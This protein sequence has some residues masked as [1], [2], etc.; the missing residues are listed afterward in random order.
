MSDLGV[1]LEALAPPIMKRAQLDALRSFKVPAIDGT[2]QSVLA[3][4]NALGFTFLNRGLL[5]LCFVRPRWIAGSLPEQDFLSSLDRMYVSETLPRD[6][7]LSWGKGWRCRLTL[8]ETLMNGRCNDMNLQGLS[9][10]VGALDDCALK[11]CHRRL[12]YRCFPQLTLMR[13]SWEDRATQ[14]SL[15]PYLCQKRNQADVNR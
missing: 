2:D 11:I 7:C 14:V 9:T 13:S 12:T 6:C 15:S 4:E 5:Y 1:P 10:T 3:A 8:A